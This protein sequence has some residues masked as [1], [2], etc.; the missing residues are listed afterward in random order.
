MSVVCPHRRNSWL[1]GYLLAPMHPAED[2]SRQERLK[3]LYQAFFRTKHI[4]HLHQNYSYHSYRR[5]RRGAPPVFLPG[6]IVTARSCRTKLSNSPIFPGRK[7]V[8]R[9]ESRSFARIDPVCRNRSSQ[10][11]RTAIERAG[12]LPERPARKLAAR[13]NAGSAG[14]AGETLGTARR[15]SK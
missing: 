13:E 9:H 11:D 10:C 8:G 1:A 14:K 5:L 12:P 3:L 4:S 2:R 7:S 15:I 6:P